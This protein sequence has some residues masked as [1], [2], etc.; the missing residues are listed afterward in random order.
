[1]TKMLPESLMIDVELLNHMMT[2]MM[3][4]SMIGMVELV[5][6][7]T[8]IILMEDGSVRLG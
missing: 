5:M 6:M 3:L 4:S 2:R 7:V 8:T 1:M